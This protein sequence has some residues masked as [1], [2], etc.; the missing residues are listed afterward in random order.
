MVSATDDSS[1]S[2][3]RVQTTTRSREEEVISQLL[4]GE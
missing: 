3:P 4:C 1:W 2:V